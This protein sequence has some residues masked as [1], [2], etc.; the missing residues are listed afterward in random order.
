MPIDHFDCGSIRL[1][2]VGVCNECAGTVRVPPVC[3]TGG[4][5]ASLIETTSL[6]GTNESGDV[7]PQCWTVRIFGVPDM[8]KGDC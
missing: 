6:H 3:R 1:D 2:V 7:S 8:V 4:T 5:L